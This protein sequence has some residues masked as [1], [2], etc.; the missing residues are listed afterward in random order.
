MFDRLLTVVAMVALLGCGGSSNLG[1]GGVGDAD[2]GANG[3]DARDDSCTTAEMCPTGQVCDPA[4]NRCAVGDTVS[5]TMHSDCG[6]AA[7]CST[8]GSCEPSSTGDSCDVEEDCISTE[9]CVGGHCGCGGDQFLAEAV[10]PNVLI[11]LD[12]SGSMGSG[13][14]SKWEIAKTAINN[15]LTTYDGAI[16]FGLSLYP[17]NSSCGLGIVNVD[18]GPN[19]GGAITTTLNATSATGSTPTGPTMNALASYAGIADVTRE[20]YMLLITDG[21]ENCGSPTSPTAATTLISQ[22][23]SVKTFVIGF[24]SGVNATALNDTAIAGGTAL[25]NGPPYYY[26]ANDAVQLQMA[27]DAIGGAVLSCTYVLDQVPENAD[28]FIY[29]N[30]TL[31]GEDPTNGWTYDP[32]D[33]TVTFTG[34][35]CDSLRTGVVTDLVIVHNCPI[36]VD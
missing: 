5:C 24:G 19:Q 21:S 12:K 17:S 2:G 9:G 34:T 10:P 22:T 25:P 13:V 1:D 20:N 28:F 3:V 27:L 7:H 33:N 18:V 26:Q 35:S 6:Q 11:V 14:D 29:F 16:Q 36:G 30:G 8:T 32:T 15:L 23:P 31:V 4:T